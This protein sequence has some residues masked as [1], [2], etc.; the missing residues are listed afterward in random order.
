M[1]WQAYPEYKAS[2]VEW[3][4]EMPAHWGIPPMYARYQVE[5]GKM[6]DE[7]RV[8]GT[9]L[10]PY[11]RNVDVQW[12]CIATEDLPE[13]DIEP[14]EYA[15]FTV[16][17]GDLLVCE[18]GEVGRA[19][20]WHGPSGTIAFQ[21]A[22]HRLRSLDTSESARFMFYTLV[23]A[24]GTG[25]FESQGNP[26]IINHLTG[27]KFRRYRFPRPP[28]AEQTEIAAFLDAEI[29]KI[30]ALIGKKRELIDRLQ[31]KRTALISRTA[32]SGLP[33]DAAATVGL[34]PAA[35]LKPTGI[36]WIAD[37]PRHWTLTRLR[38]CATIQT[39]VTLGKEYPEDLS[40]SRP[41]LRVAN[42]Q[43]GYLDLT[44][45]KETVVLSAETSR[46]ELR[47]GDVLMTEGGDFDKLGRG[48]VWYG[49]VVGCLH[50]NH[51]FAVRPD[52]RKLLPEYLSLAMTSD[53]GKHHFTRTAQQSTNLATTNQAKIKDFAFP[54]PPLP[55]QRAILDWMASQET[56]FRKVEGRMRDARS[57]M[58]ILLNDIWPI[59]KPS[60]Y[61]IHF[62]RWNKYDQ[63][64]DVW[65][66]D[67]QEWQNWQEYWPS[68]NDFN[69]PLIFSLIQFYYETDILLFGGV[70]RVLARHQKSY[71]VELTDTLGEFIG[72][73]KLRSP[74]RER[75][76]RVKFED[77][78]PS[79]EVQEI[80]REPYS[81]Q[82][83]PGYDDIDLS[84]AELEALVRNGRP[85]W[86]AALESVKG[87]YLI[88]DIKTGRRY[89]GSAYGDQGIWSRWSA[90]V[91]S[92]HGGNVEL[93]SLVSDPNLTYCR[94][95]FR[96]ALLEHRAAR[97]PD[98]LIIA[99][100]AF[101]K[102]IAT[103]WGPEW[104]RPWPRNWT[105]RGCC[106]SYAAASSSTARPC[107]WPISSRH[108]G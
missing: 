92:G 85:D 55:E 74:Y 31:E 107:V 71:E 10:L 25:I 78:Y 99:R 11:L 24:A 91:A 29:V 15:R 100:E 51:I 81:G 41:Y 1:K 33:P 8:T 35:P 101:W 46:F 98:E 50:Q 65:T 39:G 13:M 37:V 3:L 64:L 19:A 5:L 93:R 57:T 73:L 103:P 72:R 28:G 69:R 23:F 4:G 68:R 67:R 70:F 62:A 76:T 43:D 61:K 44:E 63:P 36:D 102:R 58:P 87:I 16:R 32:I 106:M 56:R 20:I 89:V 22:I 7:R 88:T 6:L 9:L 54:L 80:L 40:E 59:T 17:H 82:A 53:V 21:K 12:D 104:S 60:D 83:F 47:S 79:F 95:N 97:M 84:F 34:D 48:C 77:H 18:G 27:E 49:E 38:R 75:Q 108:T 96:F 30:D 2:G 90:Y 86:R 66:R 45:I 105:S 52:T 94:G 14:D 42:V 26:N